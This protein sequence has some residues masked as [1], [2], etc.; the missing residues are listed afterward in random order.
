MNAK[1]ALVSVILP[2]HGRFELA[3][4]AI[5]AV[6]SQTH[7]PIELIVVD[8]ASLPAFELPAEAAGLDAR[9]VRLDTNQGPGAARGAGLPIA[10]GEFIAYLDSDDYWDSRHLANLVAALAAAPEAG[11][12]YSAAMDIREGQPPALRRWSDEAHGEI[13][14]ILLWGRPWPTSACLWRRDLTRAIG[15]WMPL[16]DWEDYEHDCRAGCL[17]VKLTHLREPTCFV[18]ADAPGR[19]SA[20]PAERRKIQS[21][22]L[23]VLAMARRIRFTSWYEDLRVLGRVREILLTVAAKASEQKLRGLASRATLEAWWW[24]RPT[25]SLI[26]AS[27]LGL[28]LLWLTADRAAAR[29]LRWARRR[30]APAGSR[31]VL[32]FS[33]AGS[34]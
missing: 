6:R 3:T 33:D 20:S 14:P 34:K 28:P 9:L 23:A 10:R 30:S 4:R 22:C 13:L 1:R 32:A 16:W 18:Q 12:A 17:G 11:M 31:P 5:R 8:D 7:R 21:R 26:V 24:P 29:I 19:Q 15:D 27:G 2:V 25:G